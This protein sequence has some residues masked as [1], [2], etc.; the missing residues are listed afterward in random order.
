AILEPMRV[1]LLV[2]GCDGQLFLAALLHRCERIL[3]RCRH[4][5]AWP[6]TDFSSHMPLPRCLSIILT[7]SHTKELESSRASVFW[8]EYDLDCPDIIAKEQ[9]LMNDHIYDSACTVSEGFRHGG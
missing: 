2:V 9:G 3:H 8:G 1:Q 6:D 5:R 7:F 4:H